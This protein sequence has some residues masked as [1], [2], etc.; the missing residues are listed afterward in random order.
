[1]GVNDF[2]R[3]GVFATNLKSCK[4]TCNLFIACERVIYWVTTPLDPRFFRRPILL[5]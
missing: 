3:K 2:E 4:V 1:M 5:R